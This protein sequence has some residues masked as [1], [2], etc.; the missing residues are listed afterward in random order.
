MKN[1]ILLVY[2]VNDFFFSKENAK[3]SKEDQAAFVSHISNIVNN[4]RYKGV[5]NISIPVDTNKK[6]NV[7]KDRRPQSVTNLTLYSD[8]SLLHVNNEL[9]L[10][11]L[12]DED[13]LF[14]GDQFDFI[15][16]AKD[17]EIH[18]CGLDVNGILP[19][20][21]QELLNKDYEVTLYSGSIKPFKNTY[22]QINKM[23]GTP[24]FQYRNQKSAV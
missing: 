21:L 18:A 16:P 5:V 8:E 19:K 9:K 23:I 20:S 3:I 2:G 1:I 13:L 4:E 12:D 11:S 10:R 6:I 24:N 22:K 7:F 17:Y 14:N 15:F